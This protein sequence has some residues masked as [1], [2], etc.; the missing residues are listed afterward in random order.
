MM[1]IFVGRCLTYSKQTLHLYYFVDLGV[2]KRNIDDVYNIHILC[3]LHLSTLF[4]NYS[5]MLTN[6]NKLLNS[7]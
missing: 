6:W 5:H 3:V 4:N 2:E 7:I 1:L